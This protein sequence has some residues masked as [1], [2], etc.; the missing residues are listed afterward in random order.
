MAQQATIYALSS[1]HG[2]AGVAVIRVAGA[3]AG[4]VLDRMAAPRPKPRVAG[5]RSIRHPTTAELLDQGLVLWFPGPQSETGQDMA[6]LHVHGGRAVV[7]GVLHAIG[8][9][10]GCRLAEPGEFARRAFENGKLDL[11]GVEGLA[12]LIDAETAAQRRQALRQADGELARLYGGWRKR[13]IDALALLEAAIDFSDEADVSRDAIENA[14][15]EALSLQGVIAAHLDDGHRGEIVREGFQVVLAGPP[16]AGKSSLLN[17]LARRDVAI[18]S[19]EAGTTRDVIEVRLDL[20]GVPVVISDTAGIRD[21]AAPVEKEGIR[22]TL[23]RAQRA[24][25][26]LWL[27]DAADPVWRLPPEL[28]QLGDR[29]LTVLNK[30]DLI[31]GS[32]P[33]E[34][35]DGL[36][37]SAQTGAGLE[38][39]TKRLAEVARIRIGDSEAPALTQVRHR[40]QLEACA[41]AL[42]AF[43]SHAFEAAE[44]AAEDL[45]RAA[46]SLGRLTGSIDVEDV[47]DQIFGRFCIGK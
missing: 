29:A 10:G 38:A 40:Q 12:D 42:E 14:R 4:D 35:Q 44:M 45:R 32:L 18:V 7:Q 2:R 41:A 20:E 24:D 30:I 5:L 27:V 23:D 16:N 37:I 15:R 31:S 9:I 47:L 17:V 1:G 39:L 6:E 25:L 46:Q 13:L 26:V 11:T 33:E 19:E 22:R 8:T 43:S 28:A 21:T 3:A 34:R 36:R